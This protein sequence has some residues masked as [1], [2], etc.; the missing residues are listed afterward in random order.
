MRDGGRRFGQPLLLSWFGRP[1]CGRCSMFGRW[2]QNQERFEDR[3][4]RDFLR[5]KI[6]RAEKIAG[7]ATMQSMGDL[8]TLQ[9]Q[10][11]KEAG[12][13]NELD[14][15]NTLR[16]LR[17]ITHLVNYRRRVIRT[18]A[19]A[20]VSK[21]EYNHE[22]LR[23]CINGEILGDANPKDRDLFLLDTVLHELAH[24]FTRYFF[25]QGGH[26]KL[27]KH[28]CHLWGAA[29]FGSTH[30]QKRMKYIREGHLR[31]QINGLEA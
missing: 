27:W 16:W 8:A 10:L 20:H 24:S 31:R 6:E 1:S 15:E 7:R 11:E 14:E 18:L 13:A 17:Q 19:T 3:A 5:P 25:L 28:I 12:L 4:F 29:P 30:T 23:H 22:Y 26:G 21:I 9:R 2:K